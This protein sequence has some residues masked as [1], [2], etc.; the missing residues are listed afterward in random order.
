MVLAEEPFC[1]VCKNNP[2]EEVDHITPKCD[3]GG[4]ERENLQGICVECHKKKTIKDS[5]NVERSH[6][7]IRIVN[8]PPYAGKRSYVYSQVRRNDIVFDWDKVMAAMIPVE[9]NDISLG[10]A[11]RDA[12]V[13]HAKRIGETRKAFII[14]TDYSG[15]NDLAE[16]TGGKLIVIDNGQ[17]VS[18]K[19][20]EKDGNRKLATVI[21]AWYAN[22]AAYIKR[23]GKNKNQTELGEI[24]YG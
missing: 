6:E 17:E 9:P 20:A 15:A 1:M 22:K 14:L 2:S 24:A 12:F 23:Y 19:A 5:G 3:G 18:L 21:N 13:K 11:V 10:M 7:N 8:G 4:N 16:Q